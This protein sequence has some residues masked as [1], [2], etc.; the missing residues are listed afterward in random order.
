MRPTSSHLRSP[1]TRSWKMDSS[2][3]PLPPGPVPVQCLTTTANALNTTSPEASSLQPVIFLFSTVYSILYTLTIFPFVWILRS[4]YSLISAILLHPLYSILYFVFSWIIWPLNILMTI[5]DI[6]EVLYIP[7]VFPFFL[8]KGVEERVVTFFDPSITNFLLSQQPLTIFV[9]KI[10][11]CPPSPLSLSLLYIFVF[12]FSFLFTHL[13]SF[14]FFFF[15][16]FKI[17]KI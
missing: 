17:K 2:T 15:F 9:N 7:I 10:P 4:F 3:I 5:F 16:F 12:F 14:F 1:T 8:S 13:T 6:F 11:F